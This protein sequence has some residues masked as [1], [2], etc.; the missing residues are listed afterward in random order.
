VL[1]VT[2][3]AGHRRA[4]EALAQ[5]ITAALP[6]AEVA[7]HDLL[8]DVP[9]WLRRTYP[10]TYYVLV[11]RLSVAWGCSFALLDWRPLYRLAQPLRHL[12]NQWAA[13]RFIRSLR[14][15]PPDLILATH[16]FPADVVGG[17]KAAGWLQTPLAVVVTDLYPHRFW[18]ATSA[19]RFVVGTYEGLRTLTQRGIAPERVAVLGIPTAHGFQETFAR[20]TVLHRFGLT[21]ARRTILLTSGSKPVG[22][23]RAVVES[24]LAL[25]EA[26]PERMQL[27]VVCGHH[28]PM[29]EALQAL[30]PKH[31]MPMAVMGFI[32]TMPQAMAASD[33]IVT[34][35]GGVTVT[36]ALA[37]G[38]PL[39]LYHVIPGQEQLN[40]R[41][42]VEHGAALLER[43]P[44]RLAAA[45]RRLFEEPQRLEQMAQAARGLGHPET[46]AA[47]VSQVV[48]PLLQERAS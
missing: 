29:V 41:Y 45:V 43:R 46:A 16:F 20:E 1:Y 42:V 48:L 35:A 6:Q 17:C 40:A 14:T 25:E 47:I 15:S 36:E 26:L 8:A 12:W 7:C 18:V 38:R 34:K 9:A 4:A 27:L 44:H 30:V 13:R 3:G 21:A 23:F 11:R 28:P 5:A 39:A 22:P 10:N 32:D 19:E 33:L 24:L 31:R 2:A 37:R